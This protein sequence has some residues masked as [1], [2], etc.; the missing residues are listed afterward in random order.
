M[1]VIEEKTLEPTL[2]R[3]EI[4]VRLQQAKFS[5]KLFLA[6]N[7]LEDDS[8]GYFEET[9][10]RVARYLVAWQLGCAYGWLG[11]DA[12]G[13]VDTSSRSKRMIA[14]AAGLVAMYILDHPGCLFDDDVKPPT[15]NELRDLDG[16]QDWV[17]CRGQAWSW[18]ERY[19]MA[20]HRRLDEAFHRLKPLPNQDAQCAKVAVGRVGP[21]ADPGTPTLPGG[22]GEYRVH[23]EGDHVSIPERRVQVHEFR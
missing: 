6:D 13:G 12:D 22:E 4:D 7:H 10:A 18:Y 17:R 14:E 1:K 11:E 2:W 23:R 8:G 15:P 20:L 5:Y 21:R 9:T 3:R 19:P 16:F